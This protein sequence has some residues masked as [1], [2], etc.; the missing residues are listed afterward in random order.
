MT[1][2]APARQDHSPPGNPVP[3]TTWWPGSVLLVVAVAAVALSVPLGLVHD[4]RPG[5]GLW[6]LVVS[7]VTA[8]AAVVVL[9]RPA[10]RRAE[11]ATRRESASVAAAIGLLVAFVVLL[12]TFGVVT[13][14]VV[15]GLVWLRFLVRE[16]WLVAAT[17]PVLTGL[18]VYLL[19]VRLLT[20]PLPVDAYLPR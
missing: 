6:P 5:P 1:Q 10:L 13:A 7:V 8:V 11:P 15:V 18:A 20:V 3:A 12:A 9:A 4:G 19:F 2:P 16:R 14:T 17:V